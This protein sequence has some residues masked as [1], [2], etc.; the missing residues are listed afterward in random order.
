MLLRGVAELY[1]RDGDLAAV[2][3][4]LGPPPLWRRRPGFST[5][6]RIIL[7]QQVSL[8]SAAAAYAR[9]QGALGRVTARRVAALSVRQLRRHGLTR[10]KASYCHNL[11]QL[12]DAGELDLRVI[13]LAKDMTARRRL[14]E[15]RGIGPWTADIYLLMALGRPDVWPDGDLALVQAARQVKRLRRPPSRDRLR[16]LAATWRPWRSVAARILWHHYLSTR[17]DGPEAV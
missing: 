6:I 2:V 12:V 1:E 8:A 14:L 15:I 7:E 3:R 11:A 17:R 10:Q 13:G 16:R 9:L 5:L 4:R